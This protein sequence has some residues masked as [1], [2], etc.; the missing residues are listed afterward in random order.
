MANFIYSAI[1]KDGKTKKGKIEANNL[2]AATNILKD[3]GLYILSIDEESVLKKDI[4]IG[5][6][7]KIKDLTVFCQ[8]FEA[9]LVAG[10]SILE[11]LYLLEEQTENKYLKKII[12]DMY[13][14]VEQGEL[15][16]TSMKHHS[17][18]FPTILINM[19]EAGEKSGNLE[20]SFNRMAIHFEK[21]FKLKQS[22][23]KATTY[24][25]IVS[26]V[27]I[28]IIIMLMVVVVPTFVEMFAQ[29]GMELP[30]TT[31]TLLEISN[32]IKTKWLYL[33][34]GTVI[35]IASL[36]Y[37]SK[38]EL[39]KKM[40]SKIKLKMPIFGKVSTKIVSSRFARNV[41]TLLASGLSL[42]ETL[43]VTSK[44]V[45]NY[46]VEKGLLHAK[47]EVINGVPL[48][49][50][51]KDMNVFPPMIIHM[52]KIGENTGQLES[53]LNKIADYYDTEVETS[54]SQLTTIIEPLIMVVLA[55]VVGFIIISIV[56]PMFQMYNAL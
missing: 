48:S 18:Y 2:I 20:T 15:L 26:I 21:E 29:V 43:E 50:C 6:P 9:I 32:F 7:I 8:Q 33:I 49:K 53:I 28:L 38:S 19:V 44:V 10:I 31:K 22:V 24:P 37:Y 30:V 23:K 27:A 13:K 17:K 1:S 16:S 42:M 5:N 34:I 39:G 54:V 56:Q 47:D 40:L 35:F 46:T 51:I 52:V 25:I 4:V 12:V 36:I 3:N 55:I 45:D 11:A 41:S 14:S